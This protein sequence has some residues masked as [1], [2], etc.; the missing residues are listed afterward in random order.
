[1]A[2]VAKGARE[3]DGGKRPEFLLDGHIHRKEQMRREPTPTTLKLT[4]HE[5]KLLC[6][7]EYV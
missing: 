2:S 3:N 5:Q 6:D 1:M 4:W 7:P